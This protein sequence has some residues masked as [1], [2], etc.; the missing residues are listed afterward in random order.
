MEKSKKEKMGKIL[1]VDGALKKNNPKLHRR[2]PKIIISFISKF[3]KA[4]ALNEL[5]HNNRHFKAENFS[6]HFLED[7]NITIS[8]QGVEKLSTQKSYIFVVNH[9]LGAIDGLSML[10]VLNDFGF[11]SKMVVNDILNQVYPLRD[12]ILPLNLY[13]KLSKD[14]ISNLN[15]ILNSKKSIVIFPAG[16]TSKIKGKTIKDEDW[17]PFFIKKAQQFKRDIV[18]VHFSGRNS[19]FFYFTAW[20]RKRLKIKLN[21]EMLLLPRQIFFHRNKHFRVLLGKPIS[22]T[23]FDRSLSPSLSPKQKLVIY[24]QLANWVRDEKVYALNKII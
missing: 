14:Q 10:F 16:K 12:G 5:I 9:P 13:G 23:D 22:Y 1:D 15:A 20:I 11:D 21:L 2:L 3:I 7:L 6:K 4:D 24:N 17:N 19:G 8:T 18:P